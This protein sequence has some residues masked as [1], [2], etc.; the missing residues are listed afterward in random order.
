[1]P[2]KPTAPDTVDS[3]RVPKT[4]AILSMRASMGPHPAAAS[5]LVLSLLAMQAEDAG[6]QASCNSQSPHVLILVVLT[7]PQQ[8]TILPFV[9]PVFAR[10]FHSQK[11]CD[12]LDSSFTV[13]L[14]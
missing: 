13:L 7:L 14:H 4:L 12:A 3:S 1:M 2:I 8:K 6:F 10:P 9:K 5:M 11:F